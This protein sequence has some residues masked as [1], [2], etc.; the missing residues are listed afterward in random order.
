MSSLKVHEVRLCGAE[1][2]QVD[3]VRDVFAQRGLL[4]LGVIM[5]IPDDG[6]STLGRCHVP[7]GSTNRLRARGDE[8]PRGADR[9]RDGPEEVEHYQGSF[10]KSFLFPRSLERGS[11][12]LL[13][14]G[15][16]CE[17]LFSCAVLPCLEFC[18]QYK[19]ET[20]QLSYTLNLAP[21]Q[22]YRV[23]SRIPILVCSVGI[24]WW[25]CE[26]EIRKLPGVLLHNVAVSWSIVGVQLSCSP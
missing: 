4:E 8:S 6:F 15:V 20:T 18:G 1:T 16:L 25:C 3:A 9:V 14:L 24:L 19:N 17:R 26:F 23:L 5:A 21:S 12:A 10:A 22:I 7:V 11:L 2:A 13:A